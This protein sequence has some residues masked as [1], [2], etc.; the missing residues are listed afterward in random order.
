MA[1]QATTAWQGEAGD[2]PQGIAVDEAGYVWVALRGAD[3]VVKLGWDALSAILSFEG[4]R[5]TQPGPA[6]LLFDGT[7]VW[8]SHSYVDYET[9]GPTV[10]S[11]TVSRVSASTDQ[12][13]DVLLELE[14]CDEEAIQVGAGPSRMCWDGMYVW[15]S[16]KAHMDIFAQSLAG[17]QVVTMDVPLPIQINPVSMEVSTG[18]PPHFMGELLAVP[19]VPL[20]S[21]IDVTTY[22]VAFDNMRGLWFSF[23]QEVH[24]GAA[25]LPSVCVFRIPQNCSRGEY[26]ELAL[27]HM[28][29]GA[30]LTISDPSSSG[31]NIQTEDAGAGVIEAMLGTS[32]G[33]VPTWNAAT[34]KWVPGPPGAATDVRVKVTAADTTTDYLFN[35]IAAGSNISLNVLNPGTNEQLEI[36]AVGGSGSLTGTYTNGGGVVL[37]D[38]VYISGTDTVGRADA[39][40]LSTAPCVGFAVAVGA[41]VTVQYA[42]EVTLPSPVLVAGAEYYLAASAGQITTTAPTGANRVLQKIGYAKSSTVL[43]LNPD[44]SYA[45]LAA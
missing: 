40:G 16:A 39:S 2:L 14:I 23:Y 34:E 45:V 12:V 19:W 26:D 7:Y 18:V 13:V 36:S 15:L 17:S 33:D 31:C 42:G 22:P 4:Q 37:G 1:I 21:G 30:L 35:K 3:K 41:S 44:N 24:V 27:R 10:L 28:P 20:L 5:L 11:D 8:A 6:E 32:D 25:T 9:P 43:V 29:A 38:A